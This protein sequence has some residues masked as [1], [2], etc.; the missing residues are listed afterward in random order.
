MYNDP[1]Q[2]PQ[3]PPYGQPQPPY[4]GPPQQSYGPPQQPP[5][6]QP[7][8]GPPQQPYG[9]PQYGVPPVPGYIPQQP[10]KKRRTVLWILLGVLLV[11]VLACVGVF[12]TIFYFGTHN[13]ATDVVNKY[14]TA[15]QNQ[16]YATAYSYIDASNIT[17]NNQSITQDL[18]T[19]GAQAV[20][21]QKGK[22]TSYSIGN[23]NINS[24]TAT[25]T[26][27]VTRNGSPYDVHLKLQ[28]EGSAWKIV[29][30][31]NV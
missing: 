19:Q 31:D 30:V 26:V 23:F 17:L 25:F 22:V 24:S 20:D 5:Y 13:P 7:P 9:Q 11:L 12:G 2:P 4:Y 10:P 27:S 29:S 14:Y 3:Q 15:I 18:Y 8:Y 28:Q 6:G 16:D 21:A 1:N